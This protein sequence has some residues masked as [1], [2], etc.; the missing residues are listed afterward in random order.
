[1]GQ[2]HQ[3]FFQP[4]IIDQNTKIQKSIERIEIIKFTNNGPSVTLTTSP[5]ALEKKTS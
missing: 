3:S 1:M 5:S 4:A 2:Q